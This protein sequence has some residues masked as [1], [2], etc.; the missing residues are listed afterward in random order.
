MPNIHYNRDVRPI[1]G[2]F[3]GRGRDYLALLA[4][5]LDGARLRLEEGAVRCTTD[6]AHV[7]PFEG[8]ILRLVP[9]D[10][11]PTCSGQLS[12]PALRLAQGLTCAYIAGY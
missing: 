12:G 4:C 5:P 10:R 3:K 11:G 2:A 6:A 7:Y 1:N 9:A 8:G